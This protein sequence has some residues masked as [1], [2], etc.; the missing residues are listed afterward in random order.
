MLCK[1][2]R[3]LHHNLL[4]MHQQTYLRNL[5]HYQLRI[6]CNTRFL[7]QS[8]RSLQSTLRTMTAQLRRILLCKRKLTILCQ[9][10]WSL[11]DTLNI[12]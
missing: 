11:R 2:L 4:Y 10:W 6:R 8:Y 1:S 12:H 9:W 5:S 7:R 3:R